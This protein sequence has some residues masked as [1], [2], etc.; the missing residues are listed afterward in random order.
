MIGRKQIQIKDN[1]FK[2]LDQLPVFVYIKAPDSS[3][4]YGNSKFFEFFNNPKCCNCH[5]MTV[6][7][8][9]CES[10]LIFATLDPNKWIWG[11]CT[12]RTYV[13]ERFEY[14]DISENTYLYSGIDISDIKQVEGVVH[15]IHAALAST[16]K[17]KKQVA[18]SVCHEIR[19]PMNS[20]LGMT[21]LLS[22][23][24]LSSD[25]QKYVHILDLSSHT[26]LKFIDNMLDYFR[27]SANK[28]EKHEFDFNLTNTIHD[29]NAL[30]ESRID[31]KRLEYICH[32]ESTVPNMLC[33]DENK[34]K[35]ILINL[36]QN[37]MKFTEKGSIQLYVS[38]KKEDDSSVV[39]QFSVTDTG[40][41]IPSYLQQDIFISFVQG[42]SHRK[43][44]GIGLGLSICKQLVELM[45]GDIHVVSEEG[46]GSTFIVTLPFSKDSSIS[47]KQ[48]AIQAVD[49]LNQR[50]DIK[51]AILSVE[52]NVFNQ[53]VIN[54]FLPQ[55]MITH[56]TTGNE[57]L[58]ILKHDM[59]DL[60]LMDIQLPDMN[61][62]ELTRL[63]RNS[64]ELDFIAHNIPI[65]AVSSDNTRGVREKCL[66]AGMDEFIAKPI[67][68]DHLYKIINKVIASSFN[69]QLKN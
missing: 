48:E 45:G 51:L 2:M 25:Q 53:E 27:L 59:F 65:I 67:L 30:I 47:E 56:V 31:E 32:V 14:D 34:L 22:K 28:S 8:E 58:E 35:Q 68:Y 61:G 63:I 33:G 26:L 15:N 24:E 42:N 49:L 3:I 55:H 37:A 50:S 62:F 12:N 4:P 57:T 10:N 23:T 44:E 7:C 39:V 13:V 41:G 6:S 5:K 38:K 46:F 52:D 19:T 20:I 43:N 54:G 29:I 16:Y 69:I 11:H 9:T 36:L 64:I 66:D 18:A 21:Q 60:I 40:I 1:L 17:V